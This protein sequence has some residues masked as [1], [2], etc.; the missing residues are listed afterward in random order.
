MPVVA[1]RVGSFAER[2]ED[3]VNGWLIDPD[4]GSLAEK[5]A[6]LRDNRGELTQMRSTLEDEASRSAAD[7][8]ADYDAV[9]TH[10]ADADHDLV[11]AFPS[12]AQANALA[13]ESTEKQRAI[14]QLEYQLERARSEV[15]ERTRWARERDQVLEKERKENAHWVSQLEKDVADQIAAHR[16]TQ[17]AHTLTLEQL[18]DLR[19]R[20]EAVLASSS[21]AITRPL[22]VAR[23]LASNFMRA[24]AWKSARSAFRLRGN[25]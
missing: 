13:F 24:R 7:M 11:S 20:H 10:T 16:Q 4:P 25:R 9:L 15:K 18:D 5:A 19:A 23:R 12:Q 1:T 21:W 22:R 17:E 6:W 2:I 14:K 8:V 3:G